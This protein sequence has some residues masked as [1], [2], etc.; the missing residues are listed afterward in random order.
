MRKKLIA[1]GLALV[2]LTGLLPA[3][4][5]LTPVSDNQ[6]AGVDVS[7][8][9]GAVDFPAARA[10]GI[11]TVYIR[12]SYGSDGVDERFR[13]HYQDARDAGLHL[14]FY[15]YLTAVTVDEAREQARF[16]AGLIQGL[17]YDC[18]P[19]LDFELG[20]LSQTRAS[21]VALTF[22]EELETLTGV[23]PMIYCDSDAANHLMDDA[24]ARYPLWVA[25]WDVESPR[26]YAHWDAWTGW[27]YTDRGQVA[28]IAG[29]VD[30]DRFTEGV[31]LTDGERRPGAGTVYTVRPGDTLWA[32]ARRYGVTVE[33]IVG[34]NDIRNPNL[35]YPGQRFTIPV[36]CT[37]YTIRP[38]DTLWGIAQRYGTT[39]GALA[40]LNGISNPNLIY[41]GDVLK[42]PV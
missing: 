13:A 27:Q 30:R 21:A 25:D 40:Q 39:V 20:G 24:V 8:F 23:T 41:P 29:Y 38:G 2:L 1:L 32:I 3:A 35:I 42:I 15:H 7:V 28:G 14:G 31:L 36:D 5:A 11:G 37:R 18:R 9:Q 6:T 10:D 33:A 16:F 12:A 22:L 19:A 17:A 34:A 26:V 4:L